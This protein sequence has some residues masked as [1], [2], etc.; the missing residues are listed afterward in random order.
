M[1]L[2]V[3]SS[4]IPVYA[5]TRIRVYFPSASMW[6]TDFFDAEIFTEPIDV[7]VDRICLLKE[8]LVSLRLWHKKVTA[9]SSFVSSDVFCAPPSKDEN[10]STSS[11][12]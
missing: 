2:C 11:G 1:Y 12:R 4:R 5:Y 9:V 10:I 7:G 3:S 8:P 6:E